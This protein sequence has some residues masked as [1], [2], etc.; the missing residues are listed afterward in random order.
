MGEDQKIFQQFLGQYGGPA[1]ARRAREVQA[2][3]DNLLEACRRQREEWLAFVRL[4]LGVLFA[5]AGSDAALQMHLTDDQALETVQMLR[6]D[7]QPR[8]RLPPAPTNRSRAIIRALAELREA[9]E[10]FNRRWAA[11]IAGLNLQRINDLRD[12]YNRF[13]LLEKECALGSVRVARHAF[14]KLS[15]LRPEDLMALLPMLPMP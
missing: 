5:L 11:F 2:A 1:F 6:H 4:P 7:L 8:L 10:H 13:Y 9:I 12:G 15:P 3:F 14:Q